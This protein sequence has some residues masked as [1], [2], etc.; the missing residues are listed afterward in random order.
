MVRPGT[1]LSPEGRKGVRG[2][3]VAGMKGRM[4]LSNEL[5]VFFCIYSPFPPWES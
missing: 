5:S 2:G 3:W 1:V 4:L